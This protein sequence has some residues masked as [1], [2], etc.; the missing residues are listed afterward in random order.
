M[1][2]SLNQGDIVV[3]KFPF[4]DG[5]QSKNRP[6]LV[7]SNTNINNTGDIICMQI[8]SKFRDDL[9]TFPLHTNDLD[10]PLPLQSYLRLHKIF[11]IDKQL[12]TKNISA[13]K[14]QTFDLVIDLLFKTIQ[15]K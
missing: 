15:N 14:K 4:T 9:L 6:V 13:L 12:I 3:V 10:S 11:S 2:L 8:T 7:L 5:S 1:E